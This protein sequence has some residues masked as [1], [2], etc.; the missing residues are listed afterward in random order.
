MIPVYSVVVEMTTDMDKVT[1]LLTSHEREQLNV[2]TVQG[3]Q[4][5]IH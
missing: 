3:Q 2:R 5:G 1:T 4:F